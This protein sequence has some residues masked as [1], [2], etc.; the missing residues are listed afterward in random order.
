MSPDDYA[1][2]TQIRPGEGAR[3]SNLI[4]N[5]GG[6]FSMSLGTSGCPTEVAE[7]ARDLSTVVPQSGLLGL[8]ADTWAVAYLPSFGHRYLSAR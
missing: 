3:S 7:L 2:Q 4:I 6:Q 1:A 8:L 5:P